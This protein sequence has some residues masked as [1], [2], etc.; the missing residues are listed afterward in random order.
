M[1]LLVNVEIDTAKGNELVG[2]GTM[3][4]T[5][6]AL[7]GTLKPE[8]SYFYPHHG[9]RAFTLVVEVADSSSL[10]GLVEPFWAQLGAS[11]EVL[12]CMNAEELKTGLGRI[13]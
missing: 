5:M 6:E 10:A 3:G 9:S 1:R 12:P 13:S 2:S 11:V 7:L 4:N 8:A